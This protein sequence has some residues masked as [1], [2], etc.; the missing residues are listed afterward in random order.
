MQSESTGCPLDLLAGTLTLGRPS[1]C[2]VDYLAVSYAS[3][4]PS[5]L[6]RRGSVRDIA[7]AW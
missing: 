4:G 1:G 2:A 5:T 7:G 3:K 6:S